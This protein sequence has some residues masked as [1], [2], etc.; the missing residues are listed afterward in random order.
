M[1]VLDATTHKGFQAFADKHPQSTMADEALYLA[2]LH[3]WYS[4]GNS[5]P[6]I[7]R[8]SMARIAAEHQEGNVVLEHAADCDWLQSAIVAR[9]LGSAPDPRLSPGR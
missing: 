3:H 4:S 6:S 9:R 5:D 1:D 2:G 8:G 7:V